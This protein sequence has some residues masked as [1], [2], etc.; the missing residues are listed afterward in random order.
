MSKR[1]YDYKDVEC[2][3]CHMQ[4][5]EQDSFDVEVCAAHYDEA[6]GWEYADLQVKYAKESA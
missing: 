2:D 1:D 5:I 4:A 3:E 6:I